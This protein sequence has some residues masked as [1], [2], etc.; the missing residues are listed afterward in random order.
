MVLLIL[1]ENVASTGL[2]GERVVAVLAQ[3]L[4]VKIS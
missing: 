2:T 4:R 1:G 3:P